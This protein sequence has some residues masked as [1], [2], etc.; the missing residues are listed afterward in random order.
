LN[1]VN[2][3]HETISPIDGVVTIKIGDI[4]NTSLNYLLPTNTT[5]KPI[6]SVTMT[7]DGVA[8]VFQVINGGV[9]TSTI[10]VPTF[11]TYNFLT[12]QKQEQRSHV[13]SPRFLRY[14]AVDSCVIKAKVYYYVNDIINTKEV[15]VI[16]ATAGQDV[17]LNLSHAHMSFVPSTI[18]KSSIAAMDVYVARG[19]QVLSYIQRYIF[20]S[21]N[22]PQRNTYVYLNSLGGWDSIELVGGIT[23]ISEVES[24]DFVNNDACSVLNVDALNT[25]K[26]S[27]G[28]LIGADVR[29]LDEFLKS[30]KKYESNDFGIREI[31]VT[32]KSTI[33]DN[34]GN[35]VKCDFTYKFAKDSKY[36][37]VERVALP[38]ELNF[39]FDGCSFSIAPRLS[40]YRHADI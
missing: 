33:E 19:T 35:I 30:V 4:I 3:C 32:D 38:F 22:D 15:D 23:R 37:N 29:Q 10:D 27:S 14:V 24:A 28:Y 8:T 25:Y 6:D 40:M 11:L 9:N 5:T 1:G 2:I 17:M 16:S 36:Y 26:K 39:E 7:I 34:K 21:E 18:D 13:S 31:I 12:W 20:H